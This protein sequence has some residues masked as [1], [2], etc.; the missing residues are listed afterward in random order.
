MYMYIKGATFT[1]DRLS[2]KWQ[3]YYIRLNPLRARFRNL[4]LAGAADTGCIYRK[5]VDKIL[6][7]SSWVHVAHSNAQ[8]K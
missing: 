1:M 3:H 4:G 8:M 7:L 6:N 5:G 2:E